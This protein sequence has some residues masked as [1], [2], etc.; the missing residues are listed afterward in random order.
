MPRGRPQRVLGSE[1]ADI[2]RVTG[3]DAARSKREGLRVCRAAWLVEVSVRG[4]REIEA[5]DR[6]P[7]LRTY[8]WISELYG[9]PKTLSPGRA[10]LA[11]WYDGNGSSPIVFVALMALVFTLCATRD[12]PA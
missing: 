1:H 11:S 8:E 12:G 2:G 7:S 5:D 10:S 3:D 4:Y 9:W 6:I